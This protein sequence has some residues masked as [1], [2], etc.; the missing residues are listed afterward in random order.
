M[1]GAVQPTCPDWEK[2]RANWSQRLDEALEKTMNF[3]SIS[4]DAASE[5]DN[6]SSVSRRALL[7]AGGIAAVAGIAVAGAAGS[8]AAQTPSTPPAA[9]S[10]ISSPAPGT[11]ASGAATTG[12]TPM[13]EQP[14]QEA[15]ADELAI[16]QAEGKAYGQALAAMQAKAKN[17][18][19]WIGDYQVIVL[20]E[21]AEGLWV[22]T[23]NG[24]TWTEP[25]K[26]NA[27]LEV[28]VR[29]AG[30]GRFVPG[31]SIT[32]SLTPASGGQ[33]LGP[34]TVPFVW[35]PVFY[36]YGLNWTLP[37]SGDYRVHVHID[38]PQFSRHDQVNGKR[39]VDP[40]D[41]DVTLSIET[42]QM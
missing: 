32:A 25:D 27:H 19:Q 39:Y 22:P 33:A 15:T 12:G 42:G 28:S 29:D 9:G 20:A 40:V 41:F 2:S 3:T 23:D 36:H 16:A 17:Q 7:R 30:D 34:Q 26:S 18:T 31:L 10:V 21:K 5:R 6:D 38:P 14:S 13:P 24:L 35:H 37:N 11:P 1:I 4:A 8:A